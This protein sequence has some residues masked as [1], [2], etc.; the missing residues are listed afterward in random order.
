MYNYNSF[1][2]DQDNEDIY[3]ILGCYISDGCIYRN[4]FELISKDKDWLEVIRN[5]I[6]PNKPIEKIKNCYR[7]RG[8]NEKIK[9]WFVKQGCTPNKSLTVNFPLIQSKYIPHFIRGLI[10]GDGSISDTRNTV[11]LVSA[12]KN[13]ING[14][15][16]ELTKQNINYHLQIREPSKVIIKGIE[17]KRTSIL[18][19]TSIW[20]KDCY[21][22]LKWI[23]PN[24]TLYMPRKY[25]ISQKILTN[26]E[27]KGL[28]LENINSFRLR[29]NEN[30]PACKLSNADIDAIRN[31]WE[32]IPIEQRKKRGTKM[33][34]YKK[35][36]SQKYDITYTHMNR[37]L[38]NESR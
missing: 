27:N 23:Y 1:L 30:N 11:Y 14:F 20:G 25:N 24:T 31:S 32:S 28:S 6:S 35:T 15:N 2:F 29:A 33:N 38:K 17:C 4:T 9:N 26:F 5:K 36:I 13:L 7:Y 8:T 12:S 16:K 18:Y 37:I 3:Y 22:F 21:K 19:K 34:F 10:D